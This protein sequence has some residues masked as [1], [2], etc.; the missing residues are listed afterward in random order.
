[1]T[2]PAARSYTPIRA[3]LLSPLISC[4]PARI[5]HDEHLLA[6]AAVSE[7]AL[8]PGVCRD[9]GRRA[10][11]VRLPVDGLGPDAGAFPCAAE[12]RACRLDSQDRQ[13]VETA[14]GVAHPGGAARARATPLV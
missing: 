5:Y 10:D 6:D 13:A 1:M 9:P 4:R 12:T 8:L 7:R 2:R 3:S 14:D 11:R